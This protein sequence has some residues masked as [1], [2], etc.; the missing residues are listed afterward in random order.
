MGFYNV[1]GPDG[2]FVKNNSST[3]SFSVGGSQPR[4]SRGRFQSLNRTNTGGKVTPSLLPRG[5]DGKFLP[6]N[7]KFSARTPGKKNQ[8]VNVDQQVTHVALVVDASGSMSS[9]YPQTIKAF[10]EQLGEIKVQSYR[11]KQNTKVSVSTFSGDNREGW[12]ARISS[13]FSSTLRR[14]AVE[15]FPESVA[16]LGHHNYVVGGGTPLIDAVGET[17]QGFMD[18]RD[19][20]DP[21]HSYLLIVVTDGEENTSHTYRST[22]RDL[23]KRALLTDRVTIAFSVPPGH[24]RYIVE[25]FGVPETCVQEWE[26]TTHG[27]E[28]M[29][30]GNVLGTQSYYGARSQGA[31]KLSTFYTN[32]DY[33]TSRDLSRMTDLSASFRS[34]QVPKEVD[35][36]TFVIEKVGNYTPGSG[37]YELTK[38]E[39]IQSYKAIAI[40]DRQS[41]KIYGE[42]E[43]RTLLSLPSG[44]DVR[45]RPGN[46]ANFKIFVESD[47]S[48]RK[49][50]RGTTFLYRK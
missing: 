26:Q 2:R 12:G 43:A 19:F 18:T 7:S 34:W 23:V 3:T 48:N 14:L 50:V 47:S 44:T 41:G 9:I 22:I 4:D 49:L 5:P 46:H 1:R 37:Y 28:S 13:Y 17:L 16:P 29:T 31:T 10:N 30:K 11:A 15:Q 38:P 40:Q 35:I 27:V 36:S 24:R 39:R 6:R 25:M 8:P 21:L 20:N 33:V 42:A 32:L 45:V